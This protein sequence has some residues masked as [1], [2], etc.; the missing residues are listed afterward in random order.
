MKN[1]LIDTSIWVEYFKGNQAITGVIDKLPGTGD[2]SLFHST[3]AS[4][5]AS[6]ETKNRPL[7]H[8]VP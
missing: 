1:I 4:T 8:P 5:P 7:F 6:L 2:G 3:L